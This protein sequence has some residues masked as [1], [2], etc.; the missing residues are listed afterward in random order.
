M[1]SFSTSFWMNKPKAFGSRPRCSARA[2]NIAAQMYPIELAVV[3]TWLIR[4]S[5]IP[6][7]R[8][9]MSARL[10]IATP[11]LPT[12]PAAAGSSESR[13]SWVGRSSATE[14]PVTPASRRARNRSFVSDAVPNPAY[15]PMIHGPGRGLIP[16]VYGN[17]PGCSAPSGA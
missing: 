6:S 17:S 7:I 1:N 14:N 2:T 16:R 8:I 10:S 11:T 3:R 15:W 13:P 9:S 5:G 12:S 4:S